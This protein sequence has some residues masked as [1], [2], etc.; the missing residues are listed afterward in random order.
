MIQKSD[1]L[2]CKGRLWC[3]LSKCPILE[4][5]NFSLNLSNKLQ[6]TSFSGSSPPGVFV[7]W[8]DYPNISIAPLSLPAVEE[9]SFVMDEPE[10][11]FGL[12]QEQ[13]ISFRQAL[14]R[15]NKKENV[16]SAANPS[17]TLSQI[18]EMVMSSKPLEIEVELKHKLIPRLSFDGFSAPMGPSAL[19][20][21]FQLIEEPHIPKKIDYLTSDTDIKALDAISELYNSKI[22]VNSLQKLLAAG[23]LGRKRSR[24]L[25]P[26]RWS[27]TAV[28]SNLSNEM[29]K[30]IKSFAKIDSVKL[31]HSNYLDNHFFVLLFPSKWCFEQLEAW[32]PKGIWTP[33]QSS[34]S[35]AADFEFF[36]GRKDY[37]SNVEGAYYS[38]RLAVC[39]YLKKEK[40]QSGC[41]VFREIGSDYRV[42]LG[43]WVIRENMRNALKQKPLI[44]YSVDSSL[45]YL[46]QK[47]NVPLN[48]YRKHSKLLDAIKNQTKIS[49]FF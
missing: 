17:R 8:K 13:I 25:T 3:S 14:L 35:I 46:S 32:M 7:S 24:K 28:D 29:L 49:Q 20:K 9:S 23:L 21:S 5:Y 34:V 45:Q 44:F 12:E 27:I 43:V 16:F 11:W 39:E 47:M 38:S 10:Q 2:R 37:A 19:M 41:I 30:E 40:K 48:E 22:S 26:T 1:C 31:F 6:G 4:K 15:A 42:P 33:E 36:K 18:Q